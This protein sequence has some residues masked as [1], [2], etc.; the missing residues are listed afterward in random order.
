[1]P[2]LG[3]SEVH[4]RLFTGLVYPSSSGVGLLESHLRLRS[5][6]RQSLKCGCGQPRD[7]LRV[8]KALV[9]SAV[10]QELTR[11]FKEET[12]IIGADLC[13]LGEAVPVAI[14]SMVQ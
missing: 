14:G 9:I 13:L 10:A 4:H 2:L 8:T 1:M 5:S 6:R 12:E 3:I 7:E 11:I